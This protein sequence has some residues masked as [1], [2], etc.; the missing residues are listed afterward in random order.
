MVF[1]CPL[2]ARAWNKA[3]VRVA[4]CLVGF[5]LSS[6]VFAESSAQDEAD[7]A[8][9][10][11]SL[12]ALP[13]ASISKILALAASLQLDRKGYNS[14]TLAQVDA[15]SLQE[16]GTILARDES[17]NAN[18]LLLVESSEKANSLSLRLA[19]FDKGSGKWVADVERSGPEDML[20]DEMIFQALDDL[21]DRVAA[22]APIKAKQPKAESVPVVPVQ[23][24]APPVQSAPP[25]ASEA[26]V[27]ASE[28]APPSTNG[29]SPKAA[30]TPLPPVEAAIALPKPEAPRGP[31][32][33]ELGFSGAPFLAGGDEGS[34]FQVA[35]DAGARITWYF[36]GRSLAFGIGLSATCMAL[37][38]QGPLESSTGILVPLALDLHLSG[39]TENGQLRPYVHAAF[40]EALMS[41]QT[42]LYGNRSAFLPYA[43]AGLGLGWVLGSGLGLSIDLSYLV[44]LDGEDLI[45]GFNPAVEIDIPVGKRP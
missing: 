5:L 6:I 8:V 19:W 12:D 37:Q 7:V 14:V 1:R 11:R 27:P 44:F 3:Q 39:R 21:L 2:S 40:G 23:N 28:A 33:L 38:A 22:I 15:A 16:P 32:G 25:P 43:G 13:D 45:M 9:V 26:P 10:A 4:I 31:S 18:Y 35:G 29:T 34:F 41:L 24:E 20:V 36:P 30:E 42:P 17:K